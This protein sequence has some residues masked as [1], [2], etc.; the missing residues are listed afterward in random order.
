MGF[1]P[2]DVNSVTSESG[3]FVVFVGV[4]LSS[5][6][7]L[8]SAS[9]RGS[10]GSLVAFDSLCNAVDVISGLEV[11]N[12]EPKLRLPTGVAF[13]DEA[14]PCFLF[15]FNDRSP[16]FNAL[17]LSRP[18]FTPFVVFTTETSLVGIVVGIVAGI[19][20]LTG[21]FNT[22]LALI[23]SHFFDRALSF[24]RPLYCVDTKFV[25]GVSPT[26]KLMRRSSSAMNQTQMN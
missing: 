8:D 20:D 10:L 23:L 3:L 1:I 24:H 17:S 18:P 22:L 4:F 19:V 25:P 14:T 26:S 9:I 5:L 12:E 21:P 16:S 6:A 15:L 13:D 11:N 2:N 7:S